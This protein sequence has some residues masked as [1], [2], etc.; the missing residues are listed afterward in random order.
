[1]SYHDLLV[2]TPLATVPLSAIVSGGEPAH[3]PGV[4]G[5]HPHTHGSGIAALGVADG[6]GA[7]VGGEFDREGLG[8]GLEERLE[9]VL[10][11]QSRA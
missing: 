9:G 5:L 2:S 1:M 7:D 10:S 11:A 3:L 6:E 8:R 4:M